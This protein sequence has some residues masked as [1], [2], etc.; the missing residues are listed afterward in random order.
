M[1]PQVEG[2]ERYLWSTGETTPTISVRIPGWYSVTITTDCDETTGEVWVELVEL[3]LSLGQDRVV[4]RGA[5]IDIH[6]RIRTNSDIGYYYWSENTEE[7][8]IQCSTCEVAEARI[9]EPKTYQLQVS[10]I[11]GCVATDA[12]N[13]D[14]ESVALDV[15]NAFSPDN[16]GKNDVFYIHGRSDYHIN[17]F[18][19]F[20]RWGN[21]MHQVNSGTTNA[22]DFG[23][24]GS[25]QGKPMDA[26]VYVWYAE[27]T[28]KDGTIEKR[29]GDVFLRR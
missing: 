11:E 6:P 21:L 19:I 3:G 29:Q 26:G 9:L 4:E 28:Y 18:R 1:D 25:C 16:D 13:V 27:I 22:E 8:T 5:A 12:V 7:T 15:P 17:N 23:W 14:L 20:D 2:A 10:T 24:N